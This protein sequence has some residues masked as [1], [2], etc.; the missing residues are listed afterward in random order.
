MNF[1]VQADSVFPKWRDVMVM[2]T[3]VILV[4][5]SLAVVSGTT[6]HP[7]T[8]L[9]NPFPYGPVNTDIAW[10]YVKSLDITILRCRT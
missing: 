8:P 2:M 5:R 4:T 9:P 10:L 1:D 6:P 7:P 3:V